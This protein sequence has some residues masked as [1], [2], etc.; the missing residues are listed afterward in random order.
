MNQDEDVPTRV[1]RGALR[2]RSVD[3]EA[4]P[5]KPAGAA[6]SVTPKKTNSTTK[7]STALNAIQES[8]GGRP[9]TP[10]VGRTTRRR[11]SETIDTPTSLPNKLV[12]NLKEAESTSSEP[13]RRS[14]NTSLTEENLNELNATY[15]GNS[16]TLTTRSR[17]P[18][19]LRASHEALASI[20]SPQPVIGVR[21]S[22]RRNSITS[23]DGNSSVQSLP[24]TGSKL[25]PSVRALKDDTIIEEDDR[26]DRAESVSSDTSTRQTRAQSALSTVSLS[27]ASPRSSPASPVLSIK[28]ESTP[29]RVS[30][31]P[32][33]AI[34]PLSLSKPSPR[35]KNVSFS[36]GSIRDD[37]QSSLPKTPTSLS[38]EMFVV[39]EDLRNSSELKGASPRVAAAVNASP[40]MSQKKSTLVQSNASPQR[41]NMDSENQPLNET[42]MS[43]S[44]DKMND[45][46][47]S[48][49]AAENDERSEGATTVHDVSGIDVLDAAVK[50]TT[51][52]TAVEA[53]DTVVND[54]SRMANKS[55]SEENKFS[56]SWSQSVRRS[57]TKGI[58]EY[59]VRKQEEQAR[60]EE[61]KATL[62][63]ASLDSSLKTRSPVTKQ[64]LKE[65]EDEEEEE[66][67]DLIEEEEETRPHNEF[68]DDEALE[69]EDYQSCDSMDSELRKEMAENEIP[70]QGEDLGS[71][72]TDENDEPEDEDD[73][74]NDSWIVSD[75][76]GEEMEPMEEDELLQSSNDDEVLPVVDE[77]AGSASKQPNKATR[78]RRRI[79][80]PVDDSDEEEKP[81]SPAKSP[82]RNTANIRRSATPALSGEKENLTPVEKTDTSDSNDVVRPVEKTTPSVKSA[83]MAA[84]DVGEE[85]ET[86]LGVQT[87][88]TVGI[89][90]PKKVDLKS[91]SPVTTVTPK[92]AGD[93]KEAVS[94]SDVEQDAKDCSTVMFEDVD[95]NE[96]TD[97][98]IGEEEMEI[99]DTSAL[100]T[101]LSKSPKKPI[102]SRKSFPANAEHMTKP[103]VAVVAAGA[104]KSLPA[105]A[106]LLTTNEKTDAVENVEEIDDNSQD[107]PSSSPEQ[108]KTQN[109]SLAVE[110]TL[111]Q[112]KPDASNAGRKSMP[113]VSLVSAQFYIGAA[114]KRNT[115]AGSDTNAVTSTPKQVA[116]E[117]ASP[118]KNKK[119]KKT[120]AADGT[121]VVPNPFALAKGGKLKSRV[122]L[123]SSVAAATGQ[124]Q[125][126]KKARLSLPSQLGKEDSPSQPEPASQQPEPM[127]V[128]DVVPDE[129]NDVANGEEGQESQTDDET[130]EDDDDAVQEVQ[131]DEK[132]RT[133]VPKPKPKA[134]EDYDLANI[135]V[136]CNEF[137]REDKERKKQLASVLRKKKEEKKKL[138]ELEKQQELEAARTAAVSAQAANKDDPNSTNASTGNDSTAQG[139]E[140]LKKK[141]KRKPKKVNYVLEEL[142]ETKKERM[143][144]A[145]R[146]KLEVIERRK[147]RK[148]ERQL[149]KKIHQDK[150]NGH[151]GGGNGAMVAAS[152]IGAKLEKM[153]KKQKSKLAKQE[154]EKSSEPPVRVALSAFA[155]FNEIT[156]ANN[157]MELSRPS[158][159]TKEGKLIKADH[160]PAEK[161]QQLKP[162]EQATKTVDSVQKAP[163]ESPYAKKK[164][165]VDEQLEEADR[166]MDASASDQSAAS[167]SLSKDANKVSKKQKK[168]LAATTT[169]SK[170]PPKGESESRKEVVEVTAEPAEPT[171]KPEK[172]KEK[173]VKE[174]QVAELTSNE[175]DPGTV[176][177]QKKSK[178][179]TEN[180]ESAPRKE[181]V[182]VIPAPAEPAAKVENPKVKKVKEQL[183][184]FASHEA[185]PGTVPKQK[186]TK[187]IKQME[188]GEENLP[189]AMDNRSA[190]P[191]TTGSNV[192]KGNKKLA[193]QT[194]EP[195]AAVPA[196]KRK[197]DQLGDGS[198][199][200]STPRPAKH[201]KLRVLQRIE[202]GGFFE[203]SVT[204][205]KVRAK[206][207]FG[208]DERQATP[209]KQLG[210]RVSS[211][212][213]TGQD[214]LRDIAT[215][216]K[217]PSKDGRKPSKFGDAVA[218]ERN[219]SLP[220][221]VWTSSG[222]FLELDEGGSGERKKTQKSMPTSNAATETGYIQLKTQSNGD[223]SLK[224]LRSGPAA[225]KPHRVDPATASQSLLNF[226]RQQLLEKTA[227][228]RDK[229]KSHRV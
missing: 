140:S 116:K 108:K 199:L 171:T 224:K 81:A 155:V 65:E 1:T 121:S 32:R 170:G 191:E 188:A 17:T 213:P 73:D 206:R 94:V 203:E 14:R 153:K 166:K 27:A 98:Q 2:R 122:S 141:K 222:V 225:D 106:K 164:Q 18:A 68:V 56:S 26:D 124:Q 29:P 79:V 179:I 177:K 23:D 115:I 63:Q 129:E 117:L 138:R 57:A 92:K 107:E 93:K 66:T 22:T 167:S 87:T 207:N 48:M 156:T 154:K 15:E 37:H 6:V 185:D 85:K 143:E 102:M 83:S 91:P 130:A 180:G 219:A 217:K 174:Q 3:Q 64:Q 208:F 146:R 184:K 204:P 172:A 5:Q 61:E 226:K 218:A 128:D 86:R 100:S 12:Q 127:E 229:K 149:E 40:K 114:K 176:P 51:I 58:D 221:P 8:D 13:G 157:Q 54:N 187:K 119:E 112:P 62:Q 197:R 103:Q 195:T 47:T 200:A 132:H 77:S 133:K 96:E 70:E 101:S 74:G 147:Q 34:T 211:L 88:P 55:L 20:G 227:H 120:V 189:S 113:P 50:D 136:R 194:S 205:D 71:E 196:K 183:A 24:V 111:D 148:K 99:G 36:E 152:G 214:E 105:S 39:V 10:I 41:E 31:T 215:S 43:A 212:L 80:D 151:D 223:F 4:T 60:L 190:E 168:K 30:K 7:R 161:K 49:I 104:R 192:K 139:E 110:V 45:S 25:G 158:V 135:L 95:K 198:S 162:A 44:K 90:S 38:K 21:R 137:V 228:L 52:A 193:S 209:A 118:G 11:M 19:R 145:L 134:L 69:M 76:D 150:E 78:R 142:A 220:L 178:K 181:I 125:A 169:S 201:T 59:S 126:A 109:E 33:V 46:T 67:V 97:Q 42:V 16:T 160:A 210:F 173:K 159:A 53:N 165:I 28:G 89:K 9:S 182:E 163:T 75:G 72:D 186:K 35:S 202:S 144:Q 123:D 175:V 82:K 84:S 216:S 131:S